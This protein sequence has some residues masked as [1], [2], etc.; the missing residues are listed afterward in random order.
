MSK[1]RKIAPAMIRTATGRTPSQPERQNITPSNL[2]TDFYAAAVS[3]R[4]SAKVENAANTGRSDMVNMDY[5]TI[6]QRVASMSPAFAA[7][8]GQP[9]KDN[10]DE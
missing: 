2:Q 4:F 5:A 6:E 8:Y 1:K 7:P 3:G 10:A 9:E